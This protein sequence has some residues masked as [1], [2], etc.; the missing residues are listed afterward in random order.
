MGYL[1]CEAKSVIDHLIQYHQSV[2]YYIICPFLSTYVFKTSKSGV[3]FVVVG[4]ESQGLSESLAISISNA[5]NAALSTLNTQDHRWSRWL[6]AL[7]ESLG[8]VNFPAALTRLTTLTE[9]F[10]S[11]AWAAVGCDYVL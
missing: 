4:P 3:L 9:L 1:D 8:N 10:W 6:Q 2:F 7:V 5:F 11:V